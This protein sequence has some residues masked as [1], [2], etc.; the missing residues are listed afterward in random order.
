MIGADALGPLKT[1]GEKT[2]T[3]LAGTPS[4]QRILEKGYTDE[5]TAEQV[6]ADT[7]KIVGENHVDKFPNGRRVRCKGGAGGT[8]TCRASTAYMSGD[9][10]HVDCESID[11]P[12][13][14]PADMDAVDMAENVARL[15]LISAFN[16]P[17]EVSFKSK[18]AD[19]NYASGEGLQIP[20]Y[21]FA[22]FN[23]QGY[24]VLRL[25]KPPGSSATGAI[26]CWIW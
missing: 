7:F 3:T 26:L 12:G 22:L 24:E 2:F 15:V 9:D 21:A 23:C 17:V 18:T 1:V 14:L 4:L 6:D 10:T 25:N 20:D 11:A 8:V 19:A 16:G 13:S 5:I